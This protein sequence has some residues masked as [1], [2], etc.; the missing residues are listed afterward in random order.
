MQKTL[1]SSSLINASAVGSAVALSSAALQHRPLTLAGLRGFESAA[2]HLSLTRAATELHLT[3]SAVSRQVQGL[4]DEFGIALFVRKAREIVLTA[5]GKQFLLMVQK[6]LKELDSGVER[7]RRDAFSPRI[8]VNT[9]A[10]FASLWLIPRLSGFRAL[11]PTAD[12]EIG[13]TDRMIDLGLEN[14]D[15]AIRYLRRE[16]I[17][18]G[19]E[20]LMEEVLFPVV[21][22]SYTKTS[23]PLKKLEDLSRHTLIESSAGGPAEIRATWP[24]FFHEIG[25]AD[26]K[27][28]SHLKFDFIAQAFMAAQ[29]GQGVA[30][31]RTYGADMFMTGEL[32]RPID[33][34]VSTGAGCFLVVSERGQSRAEV[35]AFVA[36]LRE[37][38]VRFNEQLAVWFKARGVSPKRRQS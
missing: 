17:P 37:E 34:S 10:S 2:R 36:W 18:P 30:L 1:P 6:T 13:A 20:L 29:R 15:V 12:I 23:P 8:S 35:R 9:F 16:A 5:E 4:E 24:Q 14:V 38:V 3:Q 25:A 26:I 31:S 28:R 32:V 7:M 11:R 19:A 21:S 22:P 27:G 33:V